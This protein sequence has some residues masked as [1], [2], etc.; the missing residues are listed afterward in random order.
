M[1]YSALNYMVEQL[2]LFLLNRFSVQDRKAIL[3]SIVDESG[4]IPEENKNKIILS[5]VN[6]EHDTNRQYATVNQYDGNKNIQYN[7][8]Y[9]FN[10]DILITALFSNYDEALKF[11]SESI[12]F[13]QAK[14]VFTHENSPELDSQIEKLT[15]ELIKL[16]YSEMQNLWTALGTKYMPSVLFKVRMLSFQSNDIKSI[17]TAIQVVDKNINPDIK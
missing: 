11:L 16:D 6:L 9:N 2:N 10:L 3:G 14:H 1:I 12:Y 15:V 4:T 5:L 7:Q 8:P 13:F 17:S